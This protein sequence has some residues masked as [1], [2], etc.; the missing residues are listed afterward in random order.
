MLRA[1][2]F[3]VLS[4]GSGRESEA[5]FKERSDAVDL[6]IVDL[7][8]PDMDG[9]AVINALQEI[10]PSIP[11]VLV[12]GIRVS[13]SAWIRSESDTMVCVFSPNHTPPKSSS[14]L[15]RNCCIQNDYFPSGKNPVVGAESIATEMRAEVT[16]ITA[17]VR[18]GPWV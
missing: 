10:K 17:L 6:V 4:A 5:L 1:L 11:V 9:I 2:G 7:G 12:S 15:P 16:V 13:P 8:V 3:E 14:T 18:A